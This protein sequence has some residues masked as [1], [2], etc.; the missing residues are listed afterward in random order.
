MAYF[1]Q[2]KDFRFNGLLRQYPNAVNVL[3]FGFVFDGV[4]DNAAM[5]STLNTYLITAPAGTAIYFPPSA[6]PGLSSSRILLPSNTAIIAHPGTVTL[7]SS[8]N[9]AVNPMLVQVVT[10]AF[11]VVVYGLTIDGGGQDHTSANT[12]FQAFEGDNLLL[13]TV[14]FQNCHGIAALFSTMITNSG[15]VD[16]M[17]INCG[18]HW[19]TTQLTADR[20]QAIAFSSGSGNRSNFVRSCYFENIG[21]DAIS[22]TSQD[23]FVAENNWFTLDNGELTA[24]WINPQPTAFGAA[25]YISASTNSIVRHNNVLNAQGAGLDITSTVA[26]IDTNIVN[27]AGG[28]SIGVFGNGVNTIIGNTV[29]NSVMWAPSTLKGGIAIYLAVGDI[30]VEGNTCFDNPYGFEA[31]T[32]TWTRLYIDPDNDFTGNSLAPI[33]GAH[34]GLN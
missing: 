20:K 5:V 25:V 6:L 13:D 28:S 31:H 14:T 30:E 33:F 19:V 9:N 26:L 24:S 29:S 22:A 2:A 32:A 3:D 16:C 18:N 7:K 10:S 11:N 1:F 8:A 23:Q 21:L 34:V 12:V 17:F 4:T 27:G 15:A